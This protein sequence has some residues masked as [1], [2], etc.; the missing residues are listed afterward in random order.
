MPDRGV[1]SM[2][3]QPSLRGSVRPDLAGRFN[4]LDVLR[5][6][7]PLFA[8]TAEGQTLPPY[9]VLIHPSSCCNLRCQWCIGDH[10]PVEVWDEPRHQ[11]TLLEAAKHAPDH[12]PDT[13][14][15][16]AAMNRLVRDIVGYRRTA[17]Y[18]CDGGRREREFRVENVSFSGLIGEP[19]VSWAALLPAIEYL[20]EHDV[21]VGLFTNA[22]LMD[23]QVVGVLARAAYVNVSLDAATG[24]TYAELKFGG[25]PSG[26]A[27]F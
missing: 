7:W 4:E 18:P 13:L 17:S 27:M 20:L 2:R 12:L 14:G 15:D 23:R 5:R 1:V 3:N 22:V 19:L 10:V 8:A 9:E 26:V 16:P 21:R 6:R 25:R 24:S 11:L